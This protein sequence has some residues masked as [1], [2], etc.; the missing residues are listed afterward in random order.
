MAAVFPW[1]KTTL[2]MRV[3]ASNSTFKGTVSTKGKIVCGSKLGHIKKR[4]EAISL[5]TAH[6]NCV[7]ISS[8]VKGKDT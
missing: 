7:R 1:E 5:L 6:P 4:K 3:E 8:N 2:T